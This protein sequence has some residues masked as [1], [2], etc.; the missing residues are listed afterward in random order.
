MREFILKN[1]GRIYLILSLFF[2]SSLL[3]A[4]DITTELADRRI[5]VGETTKLS[6][7]IPGN[8]TAI[9]PVKI[10][11]VKGLEIDY[12]G[13]QMAYRNINGNVWRGIILDFTVTALRKGKFIIPP[14]V[15]TVSGKRVKSQKVTLIVTKPVYGRNDGIRRL[16]TEVLLSE[17]KVYAGEPL[18]LRYYMLSTGLRVAGIEG[19][20]K[21]PVSK[22]FILKNYDEAVDDDI[23]TIDGVDFFKSHLFTF[24]LL[25]IETGMLKAGGGTVIVSIDMPGGFFNMYRQKR[26]TFDMLNIEVMP[27]PQKDK[28][29]N[30]K[31]DVG[32]F[33]ITDDFRD[34]DIRIYDEKKINITVKGRGN[35]LT[36]SRPVIENENDKV[37]VIAEDS[38]GLIKVEGN[39]IVGEKRFVFTLIPENPGVADVGRIILNYFNPD[40]R[41][42]ETAAS[43]RIVL[44]VKGEVK[45]ERSLQF[46]SD[47]SNEYEI[48]P[49]Y[50]IIALSIAAG[51]II[52]FVLRE[53]RKLR[54]IADKKR[55]ADKKRT[56]NDEKVNFRNIMA[57]MENVLSR[58]DSGAFIN[59]AHRLL[60]YLEKDIAQKNNSSSLEKVIKLKEEIY[61]YRYGG[62]RIDKSEM[63][64]ILNE[65]NSIIELHKMNLLF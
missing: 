15:F 50:F 61:Q 36:L 35:F 62:G 46:K 5:E 24:L 60:N 18:I 49:Y 57:D 52:V 21:N 25:P 53:R 48:R 6:F 4:S 26:L 51:I 14:F 7:Q 31:G 65:I 11:S 10:P 16:K 23:K 17:N 40:T 30:F 12:S 19:M 42:Y 33:N 13:M 59:Y 3:Y 39:S 28:P 1:T 56:G 37:K 22:G 38:E 43:K 55:G 29:L 20:E 64:M 47:E 27:L 2:A 9:K 41:R 58:N 45:K 32:E 54:T 8:S 34:G 44:N 63:E